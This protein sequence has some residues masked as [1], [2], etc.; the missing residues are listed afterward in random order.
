MAVREGWF[1][2]VGSGRG[3]STRPA[4]AATLPGPPDQY[5]AP[6]GRGRYASP[7]IARVW[8]GWATAAGAEDYQ[9]HYETEVAA[10]LADVPGFCKSTTTDEIAQ[11]GYILTPGRYVGAE[12]V[13]DEGEPFDERM[14]RLVN[15]LNSQFGESAKLEQAIKSNLASIGYA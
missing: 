15:E 5:R 1:T 6:G 2:R 7:V 12:E 10:H 4:G 8:R 3:S 9:W 13:E 11:Y 14:T